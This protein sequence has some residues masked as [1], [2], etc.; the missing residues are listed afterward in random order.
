MNARSAQSLEQ[1]RLAVRF[2]TFPHDIG[3]I[4][5]TGSGGKLSAL[6]EVRDVLATV[7]AVRSDLPVVLDIAAQVPLG[8]VIDVYDQ[9]RVVGLEKVQFA[10]SA[11]G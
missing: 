6:G 9:C 5:T 8:D 7:A 1:Q 11:E 4:F 3:R 10:A 2:G